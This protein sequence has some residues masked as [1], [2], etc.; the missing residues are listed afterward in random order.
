M[1]MGGH[2][3]HTPQCAPLDK[4]ALDAKAHTLGVRSVLSMKRL[5]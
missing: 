1:R 4:N 5:K 2:T 3:L